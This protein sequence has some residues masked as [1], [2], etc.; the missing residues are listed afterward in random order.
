MTM[1][2]GNNATLQLRN[3]GSHQQPVFSGLVDGEPWRAFHAEQNGFDRTKPAL[4]LV[5]AHVDR[6]HQGT[7]VRR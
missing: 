6:V 3:D 5:G 4:R 1:S 7:H 2:P